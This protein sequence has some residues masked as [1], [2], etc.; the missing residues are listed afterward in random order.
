M[1]HITGSFFGMNTLCT[2]V[3]AL[4]FLCAC[5]NSNRS[6]QETST[7]EEAP[8]PAVQQGTEKERII[9]FFGN[10]ITAGY[11]LDVAQ[12]FPEIIQRRLDSLGY[13]YKV[14]NAGLSGETT[15]AGLNR[16]DWVLK[17]V[18]DVFVL[19][20]GANDGLRGLDL[21]ET[22]KNLLSIIERVR[23]VNS[24]VK[25]LLAG[26]MVPPNMGSRY[27]ADFQQIFPDVAGEADVNLLPFILEGVAGDPELNLED[28]IHPTAAGHE[29]VADNVWDALKPLLER[30][31][32]Q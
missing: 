20:L 18:P 8:P 4:V 3:I 5:G 10:S 32:V 26:M 11:G 29:L 24:D 7:G 28:G 21:N 2:W 25:I 14:V 9:L 19:E 16:I 17:T 6:S 13:N 30:S 27:A 15:A 1:Q 31:V 23:A 12:A 22:K